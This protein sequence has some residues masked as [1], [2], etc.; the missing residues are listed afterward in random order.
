M[1]WR[2]RLVRRV[3]TDGTVY[4]E[5]VDK[6]NVIRVSQ[7]LL[8]RLPWRWTE[9]AEQAVRCSWAQLAPVGAIPGSLD[10]PRWSD[11]ASKYPFT[12]TSGIGSTGV[13]NCWIAIECGLRTHG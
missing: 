6:G 1:W 9:L 3:E 5:L 10:V 2:G 13:Q 8:R 7:S 12:R 4:V 11:D